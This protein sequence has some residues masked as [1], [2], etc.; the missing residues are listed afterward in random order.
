MF[1]ERINKYRKSIESRYLLR[2]LGVDVVFYTLN[3]NAKKK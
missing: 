1:F 3:R 2:I